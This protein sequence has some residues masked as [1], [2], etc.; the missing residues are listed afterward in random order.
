M[1]AAPYTCVTPAYDMSQT[2]FMI[3]F[4]TSNYSA[5]C[6]CGVLK[7]RRMTTLFSKPRDTVRSPVT[8]QQ[9]PEILFVTE[10]AGA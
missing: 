4:Y 1:Y 8:L 5:S 9:S 3:I 6:F 10:L 7:N 2:G